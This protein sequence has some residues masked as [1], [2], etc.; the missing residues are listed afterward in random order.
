MKARSPLDLDEILAQ[1]ALHFSSKALRPEFMHNY[2]S[3]LVH[4]FFSNSPGSKAM[5][6][7]V[8]RWSVNDCSPT[9]ALKAIQILESTK[10][11]PTVVKNCKTGREMDVSDFKRLVAAQIASQKART[12]QRLK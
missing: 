6:L 2:S 11:K 9:S 1:S 3:R 12:Y 7:E 8:N 4:K 10:P 5:N